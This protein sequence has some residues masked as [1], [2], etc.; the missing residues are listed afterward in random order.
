M[1][2]FWQTSALCSKLSAMWQGDNVYIVEGLNIGELKPKH[3]CQ[4]HNVAISDMLEAYPNP[5]S[6]N[7]ESIA[8]SQG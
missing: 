4:C 5:K 6:I 1:P 3:Q 8:K 2:S 7:E